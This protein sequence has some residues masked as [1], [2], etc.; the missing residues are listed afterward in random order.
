MEGREGN[1][2][3]I[4]TVVSL[5]DPEHLGRIQVEYPYLD[6]QRSDWARLVTPMAGKDRGL[7]FCH[8]VGDEVI[9]AFELAD[10]RRPHILGG[11][12][13]SVDTPPRNDGDQEKNN[14]RFIKS[15]SG[16]IVKLND[17]QGAETIE[18]IDKSGGNSIVVNTAQN[19]ITVTSTKAVTVKAPT[20]EVKGDTSVSVEAP[21]ID[22][23]ASGQMNIEASAALTLK[24]GIVN[25]N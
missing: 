16:H 1:G 24:G 12:W 17:K 4:G 13:S 6:G 8:E 25:I 5:K 7:F 14:W 21:T 2:I 10:P 11:L 3:V 19:T 18:I 15:R 20:V 23:K 22:I 9:V